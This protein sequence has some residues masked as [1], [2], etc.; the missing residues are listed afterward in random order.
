MLHRFGEEFF[1]QLGKNNVYTTKDGNLRKE[2]VDIC[3]FYCEWV[4][5]CHLYVCVC[6]SI[7]VAIRAYILTFV[8]VCVDMCVCVCVLFQ[9]S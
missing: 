9:R 8:F 3:V 6:Q 7:H 2:Q 5:G 1:G 4:C